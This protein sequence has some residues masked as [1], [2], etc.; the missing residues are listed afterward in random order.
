MN[1]FKD[2]YFWVILV[3]LLPIL[4]LIYKLKEFVDVN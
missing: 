1:C 2:P 3:W 4:L